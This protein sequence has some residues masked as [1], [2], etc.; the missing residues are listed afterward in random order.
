VLLTAFLAA[1]K[2]Q[3]SA[4]VKQLSVLPFLFVAMQKS[5]VH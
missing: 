1:Q 5:C 4:S 3:S 2:E